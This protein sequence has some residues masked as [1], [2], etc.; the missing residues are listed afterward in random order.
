MIE[1]CIY[2]VFVTIH[3]GEMNWMDGAVD[4]AKAPRKPPKYQPKTFDP[5]ISCNIVEHRVSAM[6]R[7]VTDGY[8][9]RCVL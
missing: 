2:T 5:P 9:Y 3:N 6:R 1:D 4:L 8:I 7:S